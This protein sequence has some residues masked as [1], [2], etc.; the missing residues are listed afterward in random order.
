MNKHQLKVH[1]INP[2]LKDMKA[3]SREASDLVWGT[4]C[5]ESELYH[6][7]QKG[8]F[9]GHGAYGFIQMELAT[10]RDIM[11]NYIKYR[12]NLLTLY[13]K[14]HN[15]HLTL[16]ENLMGNIQ[17][18]VFMCR[19]HYLRVPAS[20]PSELKG[21]AKYWKSFYNTHIGGGE[22]EDYLDKWR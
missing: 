18:Q 19:V 7:R 6:I 3:Y 13:K 15:N 22:I 17:F 10:A 4:M 9:K 14:Y 20:I 8:C 21:Q 2:V 1:I 16:E 12:Q 11:E 5:V